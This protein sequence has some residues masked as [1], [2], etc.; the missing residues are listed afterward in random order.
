MENINVNAE[1]ITLI[2]YRLSYLEFIGTLSGLFCVWLASRQNILTWPVGI[3]NVFC[4]FLVFYHVQ[5][6][7]DMFLQIYFFV[8]AVYG[9]YT[10]KYHK[11]QHK[12]VT[13]INISSQL[14]YLG[15]IVFFSLIAGYFMTDIHLRLPEFFKQPTAFP[16]LDSFIA[17]GSIVANILMAKRVV[18]NWILWILIDIIAIYVYL[19]K[20]IIFIGILYGIY[21]LIAWYGYVGWK[22]E[23]F[24]HQS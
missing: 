23:K 5:L 6:Y 24:I 2:G 10:W 7:A 21:C 22:K 3:V 8:V 16:Y 18:E 14:M 20:G 15:I 12:P 9:W 1:L 11:D 4:L 19:Q 13:Q 17:V